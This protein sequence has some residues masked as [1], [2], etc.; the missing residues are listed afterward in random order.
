MSYS[1]DILYIYTRVSSLKQVEKYSLQAQKKLG[2]KKAEELNITYEIFE[3][4]GASAASKNL[5]DRP[6]LE[7]LLRLCF[8]G[9][10]KHLFISEFDR[11]TRN[12]EI[13]FIITKAVQEKNIKIYTENKI[14]DLNNPIDDLLSHILAGV[15]KF[16]NQLK[17]IR[18]R[19]G[20]N[21]AVKKGVWHGGIFPFGYTTKEKKLIIDKNEAKVYKKIVEWSL[22]G[23]GC[24]TIAKKLCRRLILCIPGCKK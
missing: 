23:I 13:Q 2:I 4:K 5:A 6:V 22:S 24:I 17:S 7:K 14:Y 18:S 15:S 21:E 12:T 3:E 8:E 19:R 10:V 20:M 9:K 1:N 16:E 11:L